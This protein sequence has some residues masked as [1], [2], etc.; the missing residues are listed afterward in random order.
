MILNIMM[1]A[2]LNSSTSMHSAV[3]LDAQSR[4]HKSFTKTV[5]EVKIRVLQMFLNY[6]ATMVVCGK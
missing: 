6:Y 5:M 3:W 2:P 4:Q 1:G